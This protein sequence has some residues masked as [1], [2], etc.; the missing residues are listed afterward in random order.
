MCDVFIE[1]EYVNLYLLDVLFSFGLLTSSEKP[2]LDNYMQAVEQVVKNTLESDKQL[3]KHVRFDPAFAPFVQEYS[4]DTSY[5]DA[6]N[7]PHVKR[8]LVVA[9]IPVFLSNGISIQNAR[10][11]VCQGLQQAM[12][13]GSF[14]LMAK[15][16]VNKSPSKN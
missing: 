6:A 11:G 14:I 15:R 10:E 12:Q 5:Q 1:I 9:A 8:V 4:K 13:N 2:Y 7:R 3:T 16:G